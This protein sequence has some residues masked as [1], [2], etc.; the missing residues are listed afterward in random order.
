MTDDTRPDPDALLAQIQ[1]DEARAVRGR[2]RIYFGSSA[3]VGK[4]CA[5]LQGARKLRDEG[6]DVLA[7]VV[8]TH[9]RGD[10][11]ALLEGL[12]VLPATQIEYRG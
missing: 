4:T 10:T 12:P 3:G 5:M 2:L 1:R 6:V 11:A 9:G 8:E 7:G